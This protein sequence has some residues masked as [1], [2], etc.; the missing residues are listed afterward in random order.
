M[1]DSAKMIL[2]RRQLLL[3]G[4]SLI[5]LAGCGGLLPPPDTQQIYILKPATAPAMAGPKVS[6]ALAVR[7]PSANQVLDSHRIAIMRTAD[8]MDY[9]ANA[10]WPDRLPELVAD[11]LVQ[12]FE[13]SS[14]I[15]QVG[16]SHDSLHATYVL[17]TDIRDFQARYDTPDGAPTIVVTI[18]AKLVAQKTR[19]VVASLVASQTAPASANSVDAAVQAFDSAL[20][21]AVAQIVAWALAAPTAPA[22]S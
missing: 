19:E 18:A 13:D 16:R 8:T 4:V 22:A 11:A 15:D 12:G 17:S 5:V 10:Q 9:Y 20:G 2:G 21:A 3:G 14:R 1:T 7:L 6:W